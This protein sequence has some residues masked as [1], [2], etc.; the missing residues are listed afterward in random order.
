MTGPVSHAG[1]FEPPCGFRVGAS[2]AFRKER[3]DAGHDRGRCL[4]LGDAAGCRGV[5]QAEG[6]VQEEWLPHPDGDV[7]A[8]LWQDAVLGP[9]AIAVA[10]ADRH[11]RGTAPQGEQADAVEALLEGT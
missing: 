8:R 9:E 7:A 4:L 1:W 11:D 6:L 10:N 2:V 3:C 5:W